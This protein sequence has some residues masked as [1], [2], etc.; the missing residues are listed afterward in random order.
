MNVPLLETFQ[1]LACPNCAATERT[2]ALGPGEQRMHPCPGLHGLIAP[3]VPAA[4]DVEVVAVAREDYLSGESQ[5]TGDDGRPYM[6]VETRH[7][8]G[9]TDLAVFPGVA[10]L[11]GRASE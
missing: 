1:D 5:R 7:A 4:A 3:L 8:D 2:R 11:G 9:H 10:V 6:A